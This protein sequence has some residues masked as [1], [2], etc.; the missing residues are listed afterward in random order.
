MLTFEDFGVFDLLMVWDAIDLF[1][2]GVC[3][4][5]L[6]TSINSQNFSCVNR[7]ATSLYLFNSF[8]FLPTIT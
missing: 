7:S 2:D 1:F 3:I 5:F 8:G 4:A 6:T